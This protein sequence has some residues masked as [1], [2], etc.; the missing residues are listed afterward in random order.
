MRIG[1]IFIGTFIA[2]TASAEGTTYDI[3]RAGKTCNE[4][5]TFCEYRVGKSLY[6]GILGIGSDDT[7]INFYNSDVSGDYYGSYGIFHDC[8]IVKRA[9]HLDYAFVSPRN[10]KVYRKWEACKT[11]MLDR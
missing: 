10:G 11:G 9:A 1:W 4:K 3:V 5:E 8:V 7:A 2:A 6:F